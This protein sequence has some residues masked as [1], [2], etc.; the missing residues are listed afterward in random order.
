[1]TD[2]SD[3][4]G[5]A[6]ELLKILGS[7]ITEAQSRSK[8]WYNSRPRQITIATSAAN[9]LSGRLRHAAPN[10]RRIGIAVEIDQRG[11]Q[12]I[13]AMPVVRQ[14]SQMTRNSRRSL[15]RSAKTAMTIPSLTNMAFPISEL[16]RRIRRPP[17]M[18]HAWRYQE[19]EKVVSSRL[20]PV[21]LVV[22][23][24]E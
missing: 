3:W 22:E 12:K 21:G 13:Q 10:L 9:A 2:V 8:D 6:S 23:R 7:L 20:R 19:A 16:L 17:R 18:L 5:T 4:T 11:R 1:M 14:Y 15:S 24:T